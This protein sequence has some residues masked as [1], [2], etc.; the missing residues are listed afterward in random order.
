MLAYFVEEAVALG[1]NPTAVGKDTSQIA[2]WFRSLMAAM[3]IALRKIGFD[4]FD[5]L[6][7]G[8]IVD[9]AFGAA[10]LEISGAYHGTAAEFRDFRTAHI[11]TGE[12][13]VAFGWGLYMAERFGIALD[14]MR[15]DV[16]RKQ[17]TKKGEPDITYKGIGYKELGAMNHD[18]FVSDRLEYDRRNIASTMVRDLHYDYNN[19][20]T[21]D[22]LIAKKIK[23]YE[24]GLKAAENL[25][26]K[27][28]NKLF[29]PS[30]KEIKEAQSS[31]D[32]YE[33]S[34]A[35]IKTIDPNDFDFPSKAG[36]TYKGRTKK[37]LR[38]AEMQN[39]GKDLEN[40]VAL[41][42]VRQYEQLKEDFGVPA[43]VEDVIKLE[44]EEQQNKCYLK[45]KIH[46]LTYYFL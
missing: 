21:V 38:R 23:T 20:L 28:G 39:L 22:S 30:E 13:A 35:A 41:D 33:R 40:K 12:G 6:S 19:T 18:L 8:N 4:K 9:L 36:F 31:K 45:K 43:P 11:G 5:K 32:Y 25:L 46:F 15:A 24:D 16:K 7:A 26:A 10:K 37:A 2:Q 27:E 14:Y 29:K 42:V 1:V 34:L 17:I 3:K 44:I